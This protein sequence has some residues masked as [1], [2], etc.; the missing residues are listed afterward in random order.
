MGEAN[1]VRVEDSLLSSQRVLDRRMATGDDM[2]GF[3]VRQTS[4]LAEERWTKRRQKDEPVVDDGTNPTRRT[5]EV[6]KAKRDVELSE[7]IRGLEE[8]V[9]AFEGLRAEIS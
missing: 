1:V 4:V 8:V 2:K 6:R 9:V 5:G 3:A 7:R